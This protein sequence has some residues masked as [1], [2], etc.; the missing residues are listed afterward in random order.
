MSDIQQQIQELEQQRAEAA[1]L[2]AQR[3]AAEQAHQQDIETTTAK[4][5]ELYSQQRDQALADAMQH[6]LSLVAENRR[7][8]EAML[9]A[10]E[11]FNVEE[12]AKHYNAVTA[13]FQAQQDFV[14][15][16][17]A[18]Y[19]LSIEGPAR[20]A[21]QKRFEATDSQHLAHETYLQVRR[22]KFEQAYRRFTNALQPVPAL[23]EWVNGATEQ[24]RQIRQG[25]AYCLSGVLLDP[26]PGYT[27]QQ[28][29]DAAMARRRGA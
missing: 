13:S 6:N 20:E 21:Q 25:L 7:A 12:A 15:R 11:G 1:R 10:L 17:I 23:A 22:E 14:K 26:R 4:L 24:A 19:S 16:A 8:V 2:E 27:A 29:V 9:K 3:I 18:D 28:D 5:A